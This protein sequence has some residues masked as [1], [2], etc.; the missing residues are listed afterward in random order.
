MPRYK[1]TTPPY[2]HILLTLL[3]LHPL[4]LPLVYVV[5][6]LLHMEQLSVPLAKLLQALSVLGPSRVQVPL[7]LKIQVHLIHLNMPKKK[8]TMHT[9]KRILLCTKMTIISDSNNNNNS[10]LAPLLVDHLRGHQIMIGD[11]GSQGLAMA[12]SP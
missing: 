7:T 1:L 8:K 11:P 3:S 5:T 12:M 6:F 4:L 10:S 2:P 9:T